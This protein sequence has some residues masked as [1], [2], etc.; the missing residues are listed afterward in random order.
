MR[1]Y[2]ELILQKI[3]TYGATSNLDKLILFIYNHKA[4][5]RILIE[6]YFVLLMMFLTVFGGFLYGKT[7]IKNEA[8]FCFVLLPILAIEIFIV[9]PILSIITFDN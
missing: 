5:F 8:D 7:L 4:V 2:I 3:L 9:I 6:F 1:K